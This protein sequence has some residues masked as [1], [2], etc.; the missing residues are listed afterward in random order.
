M[1]AAA[2]PCVVS[3]RATRVAVVRRVAAVWIGLA[4]PAL[5]AHPEVAGDFDGRAKAITVATAAAAAAV[6]TTEDVETIEEIGDV[7]QWALP[8]V[9]LGATWLED[10]PPGRRAF[11]KSLATSTVTVAVLKEVVEKAR[12]NA[13]GVN[14][15]P[16]GHTA[17]AFSGASFINLRYGPRWGAPAAVLAAYT[18]ASRVRAQKHFLD[19][20]VS[21]LSISVLAN[22]YFTFP[23]SERVAVT[24][25]VSEEGSGFMVQWKGAAREWGERADMPSMAPRRGLRYQWEF[26]ASSVERNDVAAPDRVSFLLD[27]TN[28]PTVTARI[29]FAYAPRE[30]QEI[31]FQ[32]APF[33]VRDRGAFADDVRFA[34]EVVPAGE[35]VDSRFLL[36][37]YRLRYRWRMR[38]SSALRFHAGGGVSFQDIVA[39]LSSEEAERRVEEGN[40]IPFAHLDVEW[41]LSETLRLS[42]EVDHGRSGDDRI[43]DA[44]LE[45][46]WQLHPRWD[47][48]AGVRAVERTVVTDRIRNELE[49]DQV[50]IAFGYSF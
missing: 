35:G 32:L 44:A 3:T 2:P 16:S 7:L 50:V 36:Y 38:P 42:M 46:R 14:S 18:G 48:S 49:R 34:G 10:D 19:D 23:A 12:P 29:E 17:A 45:L 30:R 20:V 39:A 11:L 24:P 47:L 5:S 6:L 33:E 41:L 27:E 26:G 9:A 21:G 13:K 25:L 43:R 40:F 28:N 15:F 1:A 4:V 31:V 22:R 37:D 8:A